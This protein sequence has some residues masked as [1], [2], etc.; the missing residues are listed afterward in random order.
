MTAG[1]RQ[2]PG[3]REARSLAAM[4]QRA[5]ALLAGAVPGT[6]FREGLDAATALARIVDRFGLTPPLQDVFALI[7]A[8]ECGPAPAAALAGHPLALRGLATVTLIETLL[9]PESGAALSLTGVLRQA[10]LVGA[11]PGPGLAGRALSLP[12]AVASALRGAPH[13]DPLIWT[14]LTVLP[15]E[16][17][18]AEPPSPLAK[19]LAEA[20]LA[21]TRLRPRPVLHLDMAEPSLAAHVAEDALRL[22]GLA[23]WQLDPALV[24]DLAPAEV[25]DLLTRD[26]ILCDAGLILPASTMSVAQRLHGPAILVG[27]R[28]VAAPVGPRPIASLHD[29]ARP[30]KTPAVQRDIAATLALNLSQDREA[31][32]RRR[33]AEGLDTLAE[34]IEPQAAWADLVLPPAQLAQLRG[35]A[36]AYRQGPRVLED[37]GFRAQSRRGTAISALFAGPSGTGKTMAAEVLARDL[38]GGDGALSLYRVDLSAM[39][40]KWIG[41]TQKNIGRLFD[42]AEGAGAVLLF[43]EGEA[44]FARRAAEVRD[45]HDRHANADTAYLLQRLESYTGIAIITTNLRQAVD[46]AFL[47]RFRS[48]I[49]FPFPDQ[50]QRAQIWARVFPPGV[51]CDGVDPVALSRLAIAGGFIRSMA[52]TAAYLAAEEGGPVTMARL[53]RAARMEYS[54]LGKPI[55]EA[56]LRG[57]R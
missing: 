34:R 39:I 18:D 21:Q 28:Q 9:G 30:A 38:G 1:A 45:S 16:K 13:P 32:H 5:E 57:F 15:P 14:A 31:L 56:E 20:L 27:P 29:G 6:G 46:D 11:E 48:V 17:A 25:A 3:Q 54:K 50:A 44:L 49:D 43:D 55:S 35:L 47:R 10:R 36:A 19:R 26:L 12:E 42:A 41:E 23:V 7:A 33:A 51:P 40:S 22:L 2:S 37:W 4:G 24:P 53:E 8:P 52:L